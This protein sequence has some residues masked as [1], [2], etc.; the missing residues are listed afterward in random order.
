[1]TYDVINGRSKPG[2]M[3][4]KAMLEYS[5]DVELHQLFTADKNLKIAV[6]ARVKTA[7]DMLDSVVHTLEG[8]GT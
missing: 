8:S 7:V 3:F 6:A 1:M 4:I 2:A 5:D